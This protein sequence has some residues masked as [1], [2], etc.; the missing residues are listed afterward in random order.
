MQSFG[1]KP[2]IDK[3]RMWKEELYRSLREDKVDNIMYDE[4]GNVYCVS[5][6]TGKIRQMVSIAYEKDR[7]ALKY[8]CPAS[9]YG[10]ECLGRQACM[11]NYRGKSSFGRVVR[12]PIR[13]DERVFT[14]V[15]RDSMKWERLY[16]A[17]S[18]V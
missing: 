7:K 15:L 1:I 3:R 9:A 4:R 14:P 16:K 10:F 5:L 11:E 17:R 2:L 12:V 13:T 8:R 6:V 18:S